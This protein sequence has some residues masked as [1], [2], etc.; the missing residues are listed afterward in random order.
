MIHYENYKKEII[1]CK[2]IKV[3]YAVFIIVSLSSYYVFKESNFCFIDKQMSAAQ[4]LLYFIDKPKC[5]LPSPIQSKRDG[6]LHLLEF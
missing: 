5:Q 6:R 3:K 2:I 1:L 4:S